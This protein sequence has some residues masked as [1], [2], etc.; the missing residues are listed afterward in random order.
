MLLDDRVL[1]SPPAPHDRSRIPGSRSCSFSQES[2][3]TQKS[4]LFERVVADTDQVRDRF[5]DLLRQ[6][7]RSKDL[8]RGRQ[9][10]A[11]ITRSSA[12]QDPVVGNWLIQMYLKCGSLIDASQV[13]YQLLETSVVNLVAWTALIAAYARN[14]QTKLAIRLFQQMQLEGNS[15]DRI[16]L[17]TIFEAC[18]NPEN[19]ED[20]KKIHAYL[21]CNSDVVLGSSL[22][23]M[24]GKCGSLS[25]A[26]LMF[27]S[28]EE[29]NTVAWNSLMGAFIQHD[30][31]EEAME[32]YWEMLQCGFLPSRP[33]FLTVLAAISSLESLRHALVNMYG[34]C[35]SVVEAVEV[36]DRMPR[37]DVILWSAVISAHVN[38]AEY[39]E[40]LRLFRK[41]QLEGN[42]PNNVTLVSVLS[43]CEGPQALET[44]KGIHECVVEA[45]YEGDLIV[46]NA[47]V[48]MYGKCGSLEDAWDVFHRV[49]RRS[50]VTCNGMMGA[51]A[52]QGDSSGALKLFRYM[53][54]EGI[55]FDN[56]TFLSALCACSGTSGLSHGEFFHARMLECGLELDIFVANA[57]V[58][59]YGKCGKVEAAE[60]VFEE[61]PEQDVRT[62][63]AMILAYVQNEE[64]RSGL[65]VFRHMMQSGYKPDE[66]TFAI[67][68]NAC[69][70]PRFLRDVHSLISETGISNTV[71]Q[72]ALV[73][74]YGRF[75]LLEEGYQVFEKLDQESIT[76]WNVMIASCAQSGQMEAAFSLFREMQHQGVVPNKATLLIMINGC[77]TSSEAKLLQCYWTDELLESH[78]ILK[79]ALVSLYGRCGSS[80][81]ALDIFG[82][83][84]SPPTA[85]WNSVIF[86]HVQSGRDSEAL[87][88]FWRMQQ[89]GVWPDK[90]SFVAVV[91][92]YS[93]VG[94]TEPEIDWLRAV[95]ANSD[96]EDG[97]P[98]GNALI[99]MY[100]RCGSFGKA[101]DLFDSMAERDAVTW[102]T[103]MSVSEQLEHGRDSI[104]LFRQMLQEGTPPDKVTILTVL[105]VCA[106]LPAL[107][108]GKAI[109]VWLDHTPLSANQ[110]IGNA[111]LNMYAKCG[112]RDEAR[113][114]FSVM[115]GRD[116]VSWNALIGAYGSYSR[117]R[118]AFQIFQAM[119]LEGST[120][121]A[122]TF[123][124]ILSVCSHGGLLGEAVKW[125]RWMREDYYVEAETGHYGCIVDLLGRLGRV[126]EAEEVA[127]KMPAGTDPIVWTT[128]LSACQVHGETQRGKRAAERL[129]ELDPEVTS[130]YVVLST[131]Y[132]KEE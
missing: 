100:G 30:R 27:Q 41:M 107:Q 81:E 79:V 89:A 36:F 15:P 82:R 5:V 22:I 125:F 40:S 110:M 3:L 76:S 51:C 85:C 102:N 63:N 109:C 31:V 73:V 25:E 129:V 97:V 103:M 49:P 23:T 122:V 48:S 92:A 8:A 7:S 38:C 64:E 12:P 71:V 29:W 101:R 54:H 13:F 52:V 112:S 21:S 65:L 6:C 77:S 95:I 131:I 126:P 44:G 78:N 2:L 24:Y 45:G 59:M 39:E 32:L 108:E 99:S 20:G 60:H 19:L 127:E 46:G 121:D 111:I 11:S 9:I 116:A 66:V 117:G 98:I 47:I 72:N 1:I 53:V 132:R 119:Q 58:N 55:E 83:L 70:H 68:L 88:M 96:V 4:P 120:P 35:G 130:A 43:A 93:N 118:Y 75:G 106:S 80:R 94:M 104:Q 61:L 105:N 123:T 14:G 87:K 74:M 91:K 86:A 33:T 34:K 28:M 69:Y 10:H 26:C 124:T 114:I 57:L 62:W 115:Q 50:V 18:G 56:I 128:L 37:H 84:E 42:R 90:T 16:T 113:R 67:T 17:V